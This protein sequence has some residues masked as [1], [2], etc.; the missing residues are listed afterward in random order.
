M[1]LI[2]QYEL[3]KRNVN[4]KYIYNNKRY[5]FLEKMASLKTLDES[6]GFFVSSTSTMNLN[7]VQLNGVQLTSISGVNV[8]LFDSPNRS[9]GLR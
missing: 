3:K 9:A 4:C 5:Y 2:E 6:D 8:I 7:R 1:I